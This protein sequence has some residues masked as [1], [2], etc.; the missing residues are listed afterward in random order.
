MI[1]RYLIFLT[2]IIFVS[3]NLS[4][5]TEELIA[6]KGVIDLRGYDFEKNVELKGEWEFYW[7]KTLSYNDF[8]NKVYTPDAYIT[9][10]GTWSKI[11]VDNKI[12]PDTGFATYRLVIFVDTN[13]TDR[14]M[15]KIGEIITAYKA[16]WNNEII[17]EIGKYS[18]NSVNSTPAVSVILKSV[19]FDKEKIQL[20]IHISNYEHRLN[21][22][23]HIPKIGREEKILKEA[24]TRFFIDIFLLG[25]MLVMAFYHLGL[26]LMNTKNKATLA[27][28]VISLDFAVRILFTDNYVFNFFFP[29]FSWQ[30]VSRIGYITFFVLIVSFMFFFRR[31]FGEERYK[32]I[33]IGGYIFTAVYSL[34]LFLPTIIY[35]RILFIYQIFVLV[36]FMFGIFLI[37]KYIKEKKHGVGILSISIII[38]F[39]T[40]VNDMLY[41]NDMIQSVTLTHFGVFLLIL[42]QSLT[43]AKIFTGS[44]KENKE[45]TAKLDYKNQYLQELV[46]ERTQKIEAQKQDIK[47]RNEELTVQKE[48]LHSQKEELI[49]QKELLEIHNKMLTDSVN[50]AS[51]IQRAILPD[52]S[53]IKKYF[54][55]F[56]IY[57]PKDIVS[58]DFYWFSDTSSKY[59]FFVVGDC[60][61][62]GV[63]GAFLSLIVMYLLNTSFL[64]QKHQ[65]QWRQ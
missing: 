43:L 53:N 38:L 28:F 51:T 55:G 13:N 8:E 59:V 42:G 33:F 49:C 45:L 12:I 62:H 27:F 15:L 1:K 37:I 17:E 44:F 4:G 52:N 65:F 14:F 23:F 31:A 35:T 26:F 3:F 56:I 5:Q 48:E 64:N 25:V 19:N 16:Y 50:Y 58:G 63:P 61:G 60:T 11:K 41:F 39:G 34:T 40:G 29:D 57:L 20:I 54:K 9:V 30:L 7:N 2:F 36:A 6:E 47:Q 24:N 22:I 46:A 18:E 10:P 21:G 32:K